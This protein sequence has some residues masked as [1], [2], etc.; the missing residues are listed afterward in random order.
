MPY[1]GLA[2]AFP[3]DRR[4]VIL[5]L[6]THDAA[7][8]RVNFG[9]FD[10]DA[11]EVALVTG[12]EGRRLWATLCY[13]RDAHLPTDSDSLGSDGAYLLAN[14][15]WGRPAVLDYEGQS[16]CD[17]ALRLRLFESLQSLLSVPLDETAEAFA[18]EAPRLFDATFPPRSHADRL[19]LTAVSRDWLR[20]AGAEGAP[21]R[22]A[23]ARVPA[24]FPQ[25]FCD[26]PL[27]G[28][29]FV[30][31]NKCIDLWPEASFARDPAPW[32]GLLREERRAAL[33]ET[34]FP[35]NAAALKAA[36]AAP[37]NAAA[38]PTVTVNAVTTM[39]TARRVL[40]RD[41]PGRWRDLLVERFPELDGE[42]RCAYLPFQSGGS[43]GDLRFVRLVA[44]RPQMQGDPWYMFARRDALTTLYLITRDPA[45]LRRIVDL[46]V[47]P[48]SSIITSR[49]ALLALANIGER[50]YVTA[51]VGPLFLEALAGAGTDRPGEE[52]AS[53]GQDRGKVI[54]TTTYYL[55]DW[56]PEK[57]VPV[58]R[59]LLLE[60]ESV[61]TGASE[62]TLD[63]YREGA[64]DSLSRVDTPEAGRAIVEYY[65]R[66]PSDGTP[67][68]VKSALVRSARPELVPALERSQTSRAH[69]MS[70]R[71]QRWGITSTATATPAWRSARPPRWHACAQRTTRSST[72][73]R[74]RPRSVCNYPGAVR[75]RT[76]RAD[77]LRG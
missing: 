69:R 21:L 75:I 44:E 18:V 33:E 40:A 35:S 61:V 47:D 1:E 64:L 10:S 48:S 66:L 49:A 46:A 34:A 28:P 60:P 77:S 62:A 5:R 25:W 51:D 67:D 30:R 12:E 54:S 71:Q 52:P 57:G 58:L 72:T 45:D 53:P 73:G 8:L 65:D 39:L 14:R 70:P 6:G 32:D 11:V 17:D 55:G 7:V 42:D 22:S 23:I 76:T 16:A 19:A 43:G 3:P 31:R 68:E 13:L 2:A 15:T 74:S 9:V 59:R 29:V 36:S 20:D 24:A 26:L 63:E 4:A 38:G 27:A 41:Y 37:P 56:P 50:D